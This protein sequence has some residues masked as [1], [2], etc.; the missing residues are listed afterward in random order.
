MAIRETT[1]LRGAGA[2]QSPFGRVGGGTI[3]R[4]VV[5]G[6]AQ[7]ATATAMAIARIVPAITDTLR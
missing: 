6:D 1:P 7:A 4:V 3:V 2:T 5:A